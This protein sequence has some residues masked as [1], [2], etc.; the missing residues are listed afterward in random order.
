MGKRCEKCLREYNNA[1]NKC[2][3]CGTALKE[4]EELSG[5]SKEEDRGVED[6][7]LTVP[8]LEFLITTIIIAVS[9]LGIFYLIYVT[10]AKYWSNFQND[11]Y[12]RG[13]F[14]NVKLERI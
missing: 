5:A 12:Q 3:F 13:R 14:P 11:M 1:W 7:G 9:I 2:L 4:D 6:E 8:K 10:G